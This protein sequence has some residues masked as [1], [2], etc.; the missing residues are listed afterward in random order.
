MDNK[1]NSV[2]VNIR[3]IKYIIAIIVLSVVS[4]VDTPESDKLVMVTLTNERVL[5]QN[6][7]DAFKFLNDTHH[8]LHI[9]I[10]EEDGNRET[11]FKKF[12]NALMTNNNYELIPIKEAANRYGY[13]TVIESAKR[14]D[15]L[16]DYYQSGLSMEIEGILRGYGY[17]ETVPIDSVIELY[18]ELTQ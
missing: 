16:V 10:G 8:Q 12:M 11:A 15:D 14:L 2:G 9:M 17:L 3:F 1:K 7:S 13:P 4:C 18:D 5:L 6:K